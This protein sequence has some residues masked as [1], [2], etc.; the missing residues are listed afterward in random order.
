M[1][2]SV[3]ILSRKN[4]NG[5]GNI[6]YVQAPIIPMHRTNRVGDNADPEKEFPIDKQYIYDRGHV[7]ALSL[8]GANVPGNV[9]PQTAFCLATTWRLV[10]NGEEN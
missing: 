2:G 5:D 7:I 8:G 4:E 9:V 1:D 6:K 10:R 3:T